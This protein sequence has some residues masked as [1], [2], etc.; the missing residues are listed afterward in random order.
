MLPRAIAMPDPCA[1][2][3]D[4]V[5]GRDGYRTANGDIVG[6]GQTRGEVA[7]SLGIDGA[8]LTSVTYATKGTLA[9]HPAE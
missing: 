3:K 9:V 4:K 6:I 2:G 1:A 5:E 8:S 7:K